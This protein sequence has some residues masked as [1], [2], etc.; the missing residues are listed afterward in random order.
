MAK[1]KGLQRKYPTR[2]KES[3]WQT[4]LT[5]CY[6]WIHK[7][8]RSRT[9]DKKQRMWWSIS[10]REE[11][12][13][14]ALSNPVGLKLFKLI[15]NTTSIDSSQV[16]TSDL[17]LSQTNVTRKQFYSNM[18]RLVNKT[19]LVSRNSGSYS[20]SNYGK[21]VFQGL[22]IINRGSRCFWTLKAL[23]K[24]GISSSDIPVEQI[25]EISAKLIED[26]DI[27]RIVFEPIMI[28]MQ[29]KDVLYGSPYDQR[30]NKIEKR[31]KTRG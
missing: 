22:K 13:I 1:N 18:S 3:D 8:D 5:E 19:G 31:N 20:L 17:L 16:T 15:A 26:E 29:K 28:D 24:D 7:S 30:R 25:L 4:N 2:F 12:T 9:E 10:S 23:D 21:V 6:G 11:D 27:R 14:K